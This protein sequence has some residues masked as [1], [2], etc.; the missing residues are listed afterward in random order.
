MTLQN[1]LF[2]RVPTLRGVTAVLIS[3]CFGF[4]VHATVSLG[5]VQ[6]G[7]FISQGYVQSWGNNYP[8]ENDGGTFDYRE[9]ALNASYSTGNLR[10]GAQVFAQSLGAYGEDKPLLDWAVVDYQFNRAIGLR[11]GRVKFPR[12]LYGEALDVDAIRPFAFL[13]TGVYNPILR[14]FF[15]SFDGGMV[16]G[17]VEIGQA[18]SID[19]KAFYGARSVDA[20]QGVADFFNTSGIYAPPGV[21]SL[22]VGSVYGVHLMWN[23]PLLGL[24]AGYS[25]NRLADVSADGDFSLAPNLGV[26]LASDGY[27]THAVSLEYFYND[28][29]F[30]AE[31]QRVVSDFNL[32]TPLFTRPNPF[33]WTNWYVSA[34][35]RINSVVELGAYYSSQTD[36]TPN[37]GEPAWYAFNRD[38]VAS[39]RFDIT[40]Q[41]IVKLEGHWIDGAMNVF[42]TIKTPNP[43]PDRRT[44]LL[45]VKSTFSF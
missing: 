35:R 33:Q 41:L 1:S 43:S 34:A 42:N 38:W 29:T 28:W 2:S 13:P 37:P 25:F 12:G 27:D 4:T 30:A 21:D 8:F 32:I 7:G 9:I 5:D 15:S 6:V 11:A 3:T 36:D 22:E 44:T 10:L 17:N 19:Y 23:P 26:S 40:D 16:Y 31:W 45:V 24:R 39:A 18:G 20:D 14:D